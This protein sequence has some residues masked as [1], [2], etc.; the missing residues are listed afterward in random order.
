MIVGIGYRILDEYTSD[1]IYVSCRAILT[2]V[3][4]NIQF[5]I[6]DIIWI[7]L[8]SNGKISI[9]RQAFPG[10]KVVPG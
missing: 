2:G 8:P 4:Q 3:T 1:S 5:K 10:W 7:W 9:Q 6:A